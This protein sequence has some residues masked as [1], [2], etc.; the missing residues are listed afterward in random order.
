MKRSFCSLFVLLAAVAVLAQDSGVRLLYA[1]FE[2]LDKDKHLQ[3]ARAGK[4]VFDS[5]AQ[6][7][8]KKPVITPKLLNAQGPLSQRVGF[9]FDIAEPNSWA[10]ASMKIVGLKDKGYLDDAAHTLIVKAE[11]LSQY[12]NLSLE[13]GAAGITQVRVR[14]LSEGN[15]V[16]AGGAYPEQFLTITNELKPYRLPLN[17]FKQPVGDWVKKKVTTEQ[18]LKKLTG[19]QISVTQVPARG[20]VVIDNVAFEK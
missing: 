17:A 1:D 12:T 9:E 15:G 20:M 16:E 7:P 13:I 18:V 2:Q 8:S 3:S 6:N 19:I 11:D 4:V 10:E 5:A 14:L